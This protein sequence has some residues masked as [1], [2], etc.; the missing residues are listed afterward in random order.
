ML[1]FKD[2]D[3]ESVISYFEGDLG[4]QTPALEYRLNNL[5][6]PKRLINY[7]NEFLGQKKKIDN[8]KLKKK[9]LNRPIKNFNDLDDLSGIE[10]SEKS[11]FRK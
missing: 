4:K 7:S 6:T 3:R 8:E 9:N 11:T 1:N 5:D 10:K 2:S